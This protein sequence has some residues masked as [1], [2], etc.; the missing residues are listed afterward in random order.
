MTT[1]ALIGDSQG[2]GLAAPLAAQ[3]PVVF[4]EPHV[5][6]TTGR[7]V[8]SPLDGALA[9]SASTILMVTG[10]NDDPLNVGA[11]DGAVARIRRAGKSL[12]VVGPVFARTDDAP[13]HDAARSALSTAAARNGVPFIDAYPMTRDLAST[14]NVHLTTAKYVTYAQRLAVAV[15]GGGGP[16]VLGAIGI[17]VV[18]LLAWRWF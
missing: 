6:W 17:A 15:K 2:Q 4:S 5:G 3:L 18:A 1:Y 11:F 8:G 12:V 16:G 9:S 13:R 14:A 7:V 10:G